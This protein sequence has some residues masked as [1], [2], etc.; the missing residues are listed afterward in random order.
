MI[1]NFFA[2]QKLLATPHIPSVL[3]HLQ[4]LVKVFMKFLRLWET[5][6]FS[7]VNQYKMLE[8]LWWSIS[9]F[10][11]LQLAIMTIITM[12]SI[13]VGSFLTMSLFE[14]VIVGR[15]WCGAFFVSTA[16][17]LF[18]CW[19]VGM[20][21]CVFACDCSNYTQI[22]SFSKCNT[23]KSTFNFCHNA[24]ISSTFF[25]C[26]AS[27]SLNPY[28]TKLSSMVF[29]L[30]V[31]LLVATINSF[32]RSKFHS[33]PTFHAKCSYWVLYSFGMLDVVFSLGWAYSPVWGG[34]PEK[35]TLMVK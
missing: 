17:T 33:G 30:N 31:K 6:N 23:C 8:K 9:V 7:K 28:I 25:F 27:N 14:N 2:S 12:G 4:N 35:G 24:T 22:A 29:D 16:L 32:D 11:T 3:V 5:S 18:I 13:C 26:R 21:F 20:V 15:D 19:W 34:I 1:R 10:Q